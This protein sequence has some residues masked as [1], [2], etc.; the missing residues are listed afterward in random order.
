MISTR[1]LLEFKW[2]SA[3]ILL[4]IYQTNILNFWYTF[5][6]DS[7]LKN[8]GNFRLNFLTEIYFIYYTIS[9]RK[10]HQNYSIMVC[11]K[12]LPEL[13]Y[14]Y[15]IEIQLIFQLVFH[16]MEKLYFRY[17]F[18]VEIMLN[19]MDYFELIL[20]AEIQLKVKLAFY[21]MIILYF[22]YI[23]QVDIMLN[24]MI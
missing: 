21:R 2:R 22:R 17:I 1:N 19:I 5:L 3:K 23:L 24:K 14:F 7:M 13:Q 15:L 6:T 12:N 18:L 8:I 20:L 4:E 9:I 11:Q 16:Q 10:V